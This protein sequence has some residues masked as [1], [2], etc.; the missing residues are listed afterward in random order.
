[1]TEAELQSMRM[2]LVKVTKKAGQEKYFLL[3]L[4][5]K[6][7]LGHTKLRFKRGKYLWKFLQ[8]EIVVEYYEWVIIQKQTVILEVTP[9]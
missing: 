4:F 7:F 2:F 5:C 9:K 6:L 3:I 1:M 8:K